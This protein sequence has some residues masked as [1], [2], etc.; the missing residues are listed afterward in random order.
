MKEQAS[1]Q[2]PSEEG[3]ID[4]FFSDQGQRAAEALVSD[5]GR[6][7]VMEF[8]VQL[9][10]PPGDLLTFDGHTYTV[11]DNPE[12]QTLIENI[13]EYG[14]LT[15]AI[16]FYNENGRLELISGHRRQYAAMKLGLPTMPV[17]IK[18]VSRDDATVIMAIDN[19]L[20]RKEKT[21]SE[22]GRTYKTLLDVMKRRQ[23]R[24][25]MDFQEAEEDTQKRSRDILAEQVGEGHTQISRY[26]AL[27]FG[28]SSYG[29]L[30]PDLLKLVDMKKIGLRPALELR[31]LP[32]DQQKKIYEI[33]EADGKTPSHDQTIR[34]NNL[35]KEGLLNDDQIKEIMAEDKPN[36]KSKA[37]K[38]MFDDPLI[39][40]LLVK[41][42]CTKKEDM[43]NRIIRALQLLDLKEQMA[44]KK[45][46][47]GS[48]IRQQKQE[49][50]D[51]L[52]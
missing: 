43:E 29:P 51:Y 1:K 15:P 32:E 5:E 22:K 49:S 6:A 45:K 10:I 27:V 41:A 52:E 37:E 25:K 35:Q 23:G 12:M 17:V 26:I 3:I 19:L 40:N 30:I 13:R 14:I 4:G 38:M 34:M 18:R 20:Q 2:N 31:K 47:S 39:R 33:Y 8:G 21:V 48:A 11:E 7:A 28:D 50:E 42:G 46:H 36:Q 16:A 9:D 44:G 24:K